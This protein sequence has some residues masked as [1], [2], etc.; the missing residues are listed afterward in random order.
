[1]P[2]KAITIQ[3]ARAH[4]LQDID[5]SIPKITCC[6]DRFVRIRQILASF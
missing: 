3:G 2:S 6:A 5:V 4:N 1:M